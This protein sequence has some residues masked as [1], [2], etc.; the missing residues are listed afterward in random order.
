M[1]GTTASSESGI[2]WYIA[3][4][5]SRVMRSSSLNITSVRLVTPRSSDCANAGSSAAIRATFSTTTGKWSA[6]SGDTSP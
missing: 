4:T 1:P 5:C 2:P 6:P 3:M